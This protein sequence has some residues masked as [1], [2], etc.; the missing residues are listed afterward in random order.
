MGSFLA[1]IESYAKVDDYTITIDTVQDNNAYLIYDLPYIMIPS[2]EAVKEKGDGFAD[3]P[4]GSG[5]FG[6]SARSRARSSSWSGTRTTGGTCRR[7]RH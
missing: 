2:M 4:V 6:L 3:A 5:P 1:N 7:S